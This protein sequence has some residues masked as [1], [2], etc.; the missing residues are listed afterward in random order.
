MSR[1]VYL[2]CYDIREPRRLRKTHQTM[3][4]YGDPLQYSVF[5]CDLSPL[6]R[7]LMEEAVRQV[8]NLQE[9]SVVIVDL[10][11][12]EGM[13]KRRIQVLGQKATA[14]RDRWIVV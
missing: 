9:D 2:V 14:G 13:A 10:G 12:A 4:G 3:L 11:P 6:E 8:A 1:N 7:V 5:V